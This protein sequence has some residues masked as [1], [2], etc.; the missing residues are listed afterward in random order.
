[1]FLLLWLRAD[2]VPEG[3]V[4]VQ[5]HLGR[6]H[7][8]AVGAGCPRHHCV[9]V[10]NRGQ[11]GVKR[12]VG[13]PVRANVVRLAS[14][15]L[16]QDELVGVKAGGGEHEPRGDVVG[17]VRLAGG[18]ERRGGRVP[19]VD[20]VAVDGHPPRQC[21]V[22][23]DRWADRVGVRRDRPE[24]DERGVEARERIVGEHP[25]RVLAVLG[26]DQLLVVR[27][28][29]GRSTRFS[30]RAVPAMTGTRLTAPVTSACRSDRGKVFAFSVGDTVPVPP[31]VKPP[32]AA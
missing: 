4:V 11:L 30:S 29:V 12:A 15:L 7:D 28:R 13:F 2:P 3:A 10:L 17:A 22:G 8:L 16:L 19:V 23:H 26:V 5:G 24:G 31:S 21:L 14:F 25:G 18:Q 6:G 1:M 32:P 9:E 20:L 27:R